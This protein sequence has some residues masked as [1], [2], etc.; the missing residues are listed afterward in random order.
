MISYSQVI[1]RKTAIAARIPKRYL[2]GRT[3][4]SIVDRKI[5]SLGCGLVE[6]DQFRE[7]QSCGVSVAGVDTDPK[8]R[9]AYTC[10]SEVP[11]GQHNAL[12][13]EH[14]LEHMTHEQVL[15]AY[16]EIARILPVNG[17][18]LITLPNVTNFGSWFNNFDH[19]NFSPPD[20][21]A[22]MLELY[23]FHVV[24]LFGWSKPGRFQRHSTL[25]DF[26]R[27]LCNFMDEQWGLTLPQYITFIGVRIEDA[28]T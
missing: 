14:V 4:D 24:D 10:L 3:W 25:N 16:Q 7:L 18:V 22:G 12:V 13:A 2:S 5:L 26:E 9:A 19:K 11:A 20:D 15:E 23:G 6:S 27:Q 21:L 8:S 28:A 17:I 1:Q